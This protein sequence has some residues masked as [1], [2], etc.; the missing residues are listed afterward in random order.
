MKKKNI[1][2]LLIVLIL[3]LLSVYLIRKDDSSSIRTELMDFAVKDT[4]SISKIFIADRNGNSVSLTRKEA[5]VWTLNDKYPPRPDM[6]RNLLRAIYSL[7]VKSRVPKAGF[8]N[9]IND[10]ASGAVKCEIYLNNNPAPF[11][12]YYV[13]GQTADALGTLMMIEN[14]SVPFVIEIPG[15]NGYLTPWYNPVQEVWLEP[16]IFRYTQEQIKSLSLKYP[17][18]PERSFSLERENERFIMKLGP[19]NTIH[20]DIDSVA[21]DNY[22][23]LYQQVFY[24]VREG[25]LKPGQR[26][27]LLGTRAINEIEIESMSGEKKKI[28][29]YPMELNESSLILQDSLGNPLTYD[30]D[31]MYGYLNYQNEWVVIQHFS[32][33]KLFQSGGNFLLKNRRR[34]P[35]LR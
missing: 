33:D 26:D 19:E 34:S 20:S 8:N 12:I 6:V 30:V 27:S 16:I 14:S 18:F 23:S 21:V 17:G 31:R 25:R 2:L 28:T 24:E 13:G 7:S 3:G 9:V 1:L 5:G 35:M 15:F 11:K 32:F 4:A 29:I 10:L 22:L